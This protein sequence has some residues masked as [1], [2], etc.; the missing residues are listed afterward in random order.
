MTD[1][2]SS[3][4][5]LYL[6]HLLL[7]ISAMFFD[8]Y[9]LGVLK[10]SSGLGA[11]VTRLGAHK[12]R[13]GAGTG[14]SHLGLTIGVGAGLHKDAVVNISSSCRLNIFSHVFANSF[15]SWI[16]KLISFSSTKTFSN[17]K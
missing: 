10:F 7:K 12:V 6:I 9:F 3:L 1:S 15:R 2:C 17:K 11:P 8:L 4:P 5:L 14:V 13:V 16:T